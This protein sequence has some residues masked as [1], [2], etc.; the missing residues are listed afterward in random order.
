MKK[1]LKV[2]LAACL[3]AMCLAVP[4]QAQGGYAGVGLGLVELDPGANKKTALGGN[5]YGGVEFGPL[6]SVEARVGATQSVSSAG[7]SSKVDWM[8]SLLAKPKFDVSGNANIYALAG[9]TMMKASFTS[10]AG[11]QQSKTKAGLAFG[12]GGELFLNYNTLL[13]LEWVRFATNADG[14]VK[15]I[16]FQGLDVNAFLIN[17]Q[18]NF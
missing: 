2:I 4:A 18:M 8:T 1:Y 5:L 13:G 16:S 17:L 6:L 11:R 7:E 9:V 3:S 12:A 15:N 10:A 14:A